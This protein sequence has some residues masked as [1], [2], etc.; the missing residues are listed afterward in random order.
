MPLFLLEDAQAAKALVILLEHVPHDVEPVGAPLVFF[1]AQLR[2]QMSLDCLANR[3]LELTE[4]NRVI[5]EVLSEEL[6]KLG[7]EAG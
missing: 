2:P 4:V 7:S 1:E 3:T 6:T 5:S